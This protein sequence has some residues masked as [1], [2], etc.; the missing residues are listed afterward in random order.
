MVPGTYEEEAAAC[1][2]SGLPVIAATDEKTPIATADAN[3][4]TN[5]LLATI[6]EFQSPPELFPSSCLHVLIPRAFNCV[7]GNTTAW[8][9]AGVN[10]T[11]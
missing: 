5:P 6:S 3:F 11:D 7:E 8:C 9:D 1:A 4:F 2:S 10:A